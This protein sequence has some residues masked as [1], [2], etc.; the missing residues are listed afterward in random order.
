MT[1]TNYDRIFIL[2]LPLLLLASLVLFSD[3]VVPFSCSLIVAILVYE[4]ITY[5]HRDIYGLAGL[6]IIAFP[7]L[8]F[9]TFTVFIAIPS[10]YVAYDKRLDLSS[11]YFVSILCFY[12]LYPAGLYLGQFLGR[13][14]LTRLRRLPRQQPVSDRYDFILFELLGALLILCLLIFAAYVLRLQQIPLIEIFK[15]PGDSERIFLMREEALKLLPM[16]TI[17]RYLIHWLRSLFVPFGIV[18]SLFLTVT[19]HKSKYKALF[20]VYFIFGIT[21]NSLT[22]E[23]SPVAAV[24]LSIAAF[25]YL[26]KRRVRAISIVGWILVVLLFPVFIM[27]FYHY[28]MENLAR[29]IFL[30]LLFRLFL[31]PSEVLYYYFDYFPR[32]H[33]FLWGR[34]SRLFSWLYPEGGFDIS[35]YV[36]KIW[37]Q[38]PHTSGYAN[39]NYLGNY[40]ANFGWIGILLSTLL[41]GI[42]IQWFYWKLLEVSRY[43]KNGLFMTCTAV[44]VPTFTFGFFSSNFTVL[45]VTR[46]LLLII[47]LL[48]FYDYINKRIRIA[49]E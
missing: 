10:V 15:N 6:R 20:L 45:I 41:V 33:D 39:A 49:T 12:I 5:Q 19:Y 32:L 36:A 7:S 23:K 26:K 21:A 38:A 42:F 27:Y 4:L 3:P 18:G 1:T 30:S 13:I 47:L 37:W 34:S 29:V 40:W 17:E 11:P 44:V 43:S 16:T 31:V 14:D 48:F 46:G 2:S 22:V 8:I 25:I 9:V 24:F 28:G 35:N